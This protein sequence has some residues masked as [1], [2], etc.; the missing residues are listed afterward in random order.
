MSKCLYTDTYAE[1]VTIMTIDTNLLTQHS[2]DKIKLNMAKHKY[3]NDLLSLVQYSV[4]VHDVHTTTLVFGHSF[5]KFSRS[6][7]SNLDV[8]YSKPQTNSYKR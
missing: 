1:I 3:K 4:N 2:C 5:Y 6:C 8:S 7:V